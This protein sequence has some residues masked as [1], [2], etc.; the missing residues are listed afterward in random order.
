L[1]P[2]E[3][4]FPTRL[5]QKSGNFV[6]IERA[7]YVSPNE[8]RGFEL[9]VPKECLS[10]KDGLFVSTAA[11]SVAESLTRQGITSFTLRKAAA[12]QPVQRT[13]ASRSDQETNRASSAASRR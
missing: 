13:G 12:S 7:Y 5:V 3:L 8:L 6:L 2:G 1:K 4:C 9:F 11:L 10:E